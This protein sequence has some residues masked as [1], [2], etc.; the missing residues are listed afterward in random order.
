[1]TADARKAGIRNAL[2]AVGVAGVVLTGCSSP[3]PVDKQIKSSRS[4]VLP[5]I[6]RIYNELYGAHLV[7][8]ASIDAGAS[9]CGD[10]DPLAKSDNQSDIQFSASALTVPYAATSLYDFTLPLEVA[11]FGPQ[12][13]GKLEA[14]GWKLRLL[15]KGSDTHPL[16]TYAVRDNG[17]DIAV[18][19]DHNAGN[20]PI[21][22]ISVSGACFNAGSDAQRIT[23]NPSHDTVDLPHP[24]S[25]P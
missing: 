20:A 24:T 8:L 3:S 6:K 23:T 17:L 13:A 5:V 19:V 4:A 14:D 11:T 2:L 18:K 22:D 1:M 7:W 15:S 21:A 12:V 9:L 10:D 16:Y 25:R